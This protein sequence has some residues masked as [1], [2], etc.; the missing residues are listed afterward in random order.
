M[1]DNINM[2]IEA[3]KIK[4]GGYYK[5]IPTLLE[6]V[7]ENRY[8]NG[9]I[10]I[11]GKLQNLYVSV[12][13]AGLSISG[14]INKYYHTDNFQKLTRQQ[15]QMAVEKLEDT[16]QIN[17]EES[18]LTRL[19]VAHN[20]I[21]SNDPKCY[22]SLLGEC[23]YYTRL[24]QPNSIYYNNHKKV[25]LFYDKVKEGKKSKQ[26]I[27]K[28]WLSRNV[29]R[30]EL[31]LLNRLSDSLNTNSPSLHSLYNEGFYMACLDVWEEEYYQIKKHRLFKPKKEDM[32]TKEGKEYLLSACIQTIGHNEINEIVS[33]WQGYFTS[34]REARRFKNSIRK[35][36]GLTE[37][38]ELIEELDAKISKVKSNY[39]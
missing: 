8:S 14:S 21:M 7:K 29:L 39:R 6:N 2:R 5:K 17:L 18:S 19:D 34:A 22:Y 15:T 32:T 12:S 20:L 16:L 11:G 23:T 30:Y 25:K 24:Q 3:G 9:H 1:Y 38:S 26:H 31:R 35:L 28:H 10:Y 37:E 13:E 33:N 27:P 36:K 4:E